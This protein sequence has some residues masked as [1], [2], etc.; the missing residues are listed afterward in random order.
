VRIKDGMPQAM[1]PLAALL[2]AAYQEVC[3]AADQVT[4]ADT[5]LQT[6][7]ADLARGSQL[8]ISC[9]RCS[10]FHLSSP[11]NTCSSQLHHSSTKHICSQSA[12]PACA[13]APALTSA[14][15]AMRCCLLDSDMRCAGAVLE[16]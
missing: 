3:E 5:A 9:L 4:A 2:E 7:S 12:A 6:A 10:A 16:A 1:S 13:T 15:C 11:D 14:L 8:I